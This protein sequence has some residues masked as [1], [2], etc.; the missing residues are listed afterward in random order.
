MVGI[1]EKD[2]ETGKKYRGRVCNGYTAVIR[3][4]LHDKNAEI[5]RLRE[6]LYQVPPEIAGRHAASGSPGPRVAP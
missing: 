6:H 3:V 5:G 2:P 1:P 4:D